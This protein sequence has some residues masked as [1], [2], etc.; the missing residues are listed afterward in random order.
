M[1][2]ATDA[3]GTLNTLSG[4]TEDTAAQPRSTSPNIPR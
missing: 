3:P 4:T 2:S 1:T